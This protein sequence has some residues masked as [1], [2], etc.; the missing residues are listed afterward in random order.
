M[1]GG[2]AMYDLFTSYNLF[3]VEKLQLALCIFVFFYSI[4]FIT[5]QL[6]LFKSRYKRLVV[7]QKI[8]TRVFINWGR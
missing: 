4:V 3:G 5:K 2:S 1:L 8:S 7:Q 6:K